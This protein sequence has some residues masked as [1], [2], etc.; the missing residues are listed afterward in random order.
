M[1]FPSLSL[2]Y[3]KNFEEGPEMDKCKSSFVVASS[4]AA[5]L[6]LVSGAAQFAET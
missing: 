5:I 1:E 2:Q 4:K 6:E 3:A